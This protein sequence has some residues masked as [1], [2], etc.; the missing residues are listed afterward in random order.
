MSESLAFLRAIIARPDDDTP[1]LVYA[2][3]LEENDQPQRAEFIR[4]QCQLARHL[5]QLVKDRK[6]ESVLNRQQELL[7]QFESRWRAELPQIPGVH[8]SEFHRGF[9]RGVAIQ[10]P[11]TFAEFASIILQAAPITE[12]RFYQATQADIRVLAQTPALLQIRKLYVA[13][14]IFGAGVARILASSPYGESVK[15]LETNGWSMTDLGVLAFL[16]NENWQSLEEWHLAWNDLTDLTAE[17]ISVCSHMQTLRVL[18]LQYNNLSTRGIQVLKKS[19]IL[20]QLRQLL[21]EGNSVS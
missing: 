18:N 1:R 10:Y 3:Y 7:C 12:L 20:S 9:I 13:V 19:P 5:S 6:L 4:L 8:W 15:I 16:Q 21:W 11:D 17:T 2:D 14:N